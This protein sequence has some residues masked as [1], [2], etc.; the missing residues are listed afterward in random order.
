MPPAMI[1]LSG[2][3]MHKRTC[4]YL[5]KV[6]AQWGASEHQGL[7]VEKDVGAV[8]EVERDDLALLQHLH[9]LPNTF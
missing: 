5:L 2:A 8:S 4:T 6:A 1:A 3:C 9:L 7:A